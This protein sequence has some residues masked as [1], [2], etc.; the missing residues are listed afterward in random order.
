M[1]GTQFSSERRFVQAKKSTSPAPKYALKSIFGQNKRGA[2]FG[3]ETRDTRDPVSVGIKLEI[4]SDC[5]QFQN[6]DTRRE[7][8]IIT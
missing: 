4:K 8:K 6:D 2:V 3:T 5:G 7:E 1:R